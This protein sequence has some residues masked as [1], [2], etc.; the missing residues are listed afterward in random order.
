MRLAI[1]LFLLVSSPVLA[2]STFTVTNI[3]DAGA[4]SLRQALLDANANP[5]A[6]TIEFNIPGAGPHIIQ[7][8]SFLT[9]V[10]APITLDGFT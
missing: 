2:Q 10:T 4:G 8:L 7:P 5:D 3:A 6:S 9:V 1:A